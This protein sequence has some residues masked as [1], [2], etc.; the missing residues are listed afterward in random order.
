MF[1]KTYITGWFEYI[2]LYKTIKFEQV[3]S[4]S[5]CIVNKCNNYTPVIENC[6]DQNLY[7]FQWN[8]SKKNYIHRICTTKSIVQFVN[9]VKF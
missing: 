7:T 6:T 9:E 8:V 4:S 2:I 5:P 3:T 1:L